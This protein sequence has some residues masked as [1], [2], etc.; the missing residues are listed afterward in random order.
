MPARFTAVF[1]FAP[2]TGREREALGVVRAY[3]R[4]AGNALGSRELSGGA[5]AGLAAGKRRADG[6]ADPTLRAAVRESVEAAASLCDGLLDAA[7]GLPAG[8]GD[9]PGG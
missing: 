7:G 8:T 9:A 5:G 3:L 2:P 1:G 6:P 4:R